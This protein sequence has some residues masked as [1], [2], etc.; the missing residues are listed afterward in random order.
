MRELRAWTR[1]PVIQLSIASSPPSPGWEEL[2]FPSPALIPCQGQPESNSQGKWHLVGRVIDVSILYP[3]IQDLWV[4]LC[5]LCTVQLLVCVI[6]TLV[7]C[8]GHLIFLTS[9]MGQPVLGA[10]D[11]TTSKTDVVLAF[12]FLT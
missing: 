8:A 3:S 12:K 4:Q 6:G 11:T 10:R 1:A 7:S 2:P 9:T 5:R